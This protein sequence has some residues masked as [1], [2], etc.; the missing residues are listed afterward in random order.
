MLSGTQSDWTESD[1]AKDTYIQ[2]KPTVLHSILGITSPTVSGDYVT[3]SVGTP[4]TGMAAQDHFIIEFRSIGVANASKKIKILFEGENTAFGLY[5]ATGT[6]EMTGA[7]V[8][9]YLW[10]MD[11]VKT[12]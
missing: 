1:S 9:T 2:H 5:D 10:Q 7:D 6:T 12:N 3:V 11:V 4:L 8:S